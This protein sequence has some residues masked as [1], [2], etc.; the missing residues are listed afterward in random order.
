MDKGFK[1]CSICGI[2]R[3]VNCYTADLQKKDGLRSN[4]KLCARGKFE[5]DRLPDQPRQH[6][7][8]RF[9]YNGVLISK[10][11]TKCKENLDTF[12]AAIAYLEEY[13]AKKTKL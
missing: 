7:A 13:N 10:I 5:L 9:E 3:R 8:T 1:V 12:K 11:C 4:C 6:F 2:E